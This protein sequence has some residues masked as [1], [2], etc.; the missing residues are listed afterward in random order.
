MIGWLR[1]LD[2]RRSIETAPYQRPGVPARVGA[3]PEEC[4]G[5]VQWRGTDGV[6]ASG[7]EAVSAALSAALGR[8]W[9]LRIYRRTAGPQQRLYQWVTDH[10]H[11]LPGVTPW[12]TRYP[13]DCAQPDS[14]GGLGSSS[15]SA[16]SD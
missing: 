16:D 3:T 1:V 8:N 15:S 6:R 9:P 5:S 10:R 14:S 4:A 13:R 11:R 2:R 7:A 12:C